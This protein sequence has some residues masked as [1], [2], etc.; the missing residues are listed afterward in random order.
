MDFQRNIG[1]FKKK[2]FPYENKAFLSFFRFNMYSIFEAVVF[3]CCSMMTSK[4]SNPFH[5]RLS[6]LK[7]GLICEEET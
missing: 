3:P 2:K 6:F 1:Y 5:I 4:L 7:M